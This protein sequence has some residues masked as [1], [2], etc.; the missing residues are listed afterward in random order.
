MIMTKEELVVV[1]SNYLHIKRAS[2]YILLESVELMIES[3]RGERLKRTQEESENSKIDAFPWKN[4][5][6]TVITTP[7]LSRIADELLRKSSTPERAEFRDITQYDKTRMYQILGERPENHDV[8]T[9]AEKVPGYSKRQYRSVITNYNR[10][11]N[12]ETGKRKLSDLDWRKIKGILL[13]ENKE[14]IRHSSKRL[15]R[16]V[17]GY[18]LHQY[19]NFIQRCK[20]GSRRY[21]QK[22][23]ELMPKGWSILHWTK[24]ETFIKSLKDKELLEIIM[25]QEDQ[26]ILKEA[27][28]Q[29]IHTL[30]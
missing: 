10:R 7:G 27:C 13:R 22:Y 3:I 17:P 29:T 9:L 30:R 1:L 18:T 2:C 24:K 26:A 14:G 25:E 28:V 21:D 23:L 19:A 4:S 12:P 8:G 16:M 20:K 5:P 11:V 15:Q 6:S